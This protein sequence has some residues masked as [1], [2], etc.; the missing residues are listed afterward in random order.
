MLSSQAL[1]VKL[2]NS[3]QASNRPFQLRFYAKSVAKKLLQESLPKKPPNNFI[4]HMQCVYLDFG[5]IDISPVVADGFHLLL[6][7]AWQRASDQLTEH[8]RTIGRLFI[9]VVYRLASP[10]TSYIDWRSVA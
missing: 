7:V 2:T 4:Y 9:V 10:P 1:V 6:H 5:E 8:N 3:L